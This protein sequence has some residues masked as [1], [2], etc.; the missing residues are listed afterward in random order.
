VNNNIS[1]PVDIYVTCE[2]FNTFN[3]YI[4]NSD[5]T[6]YDILNDQILIDIKNRGEYIEETSDYYPKFTD[7]IEY[8]EIY[9]EYSWQVKKDY[10]YTLEMKLISTDV[11][12]VKVSELFF[13]ILFGTEDL[14]FGIPKD[15]T[16]NEDPEQEVIDTI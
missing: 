3:D 10:I 15:Y 13:D 5:A 12:Y 16:S 1:V 7:I 8:Y 14:W 9:P 11:A 2:L 6:T 4:T